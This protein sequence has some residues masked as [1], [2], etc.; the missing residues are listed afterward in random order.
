[1]G[2]TAPFFDIIFI[3]TE[4]LF[5]L[6]N[7]F[8]SIFQAHV[9]KL[10]SSVDKGVIF[11]S[12]VS[13][14]EL[15]DTYINSFP[16]DIRQSFNCNSC[17]QFIKSYGGLVKINPENMM[18]TTLW[19]FEVPDEMYQRVVDNLSELVFRSNI[20]DVFVSNQPKLGT[21]FNFE[22][23]KVNNITTEIIR[24]DHF[25]YHLNKE[26]YQKVNAEKDIVPTQAT[27][28][29]TKNV[30]K[31]ALDEITP[32][33][34]QSVIDLEKDGNLY[35]G[36]EFI[37]A[38]KSFQK[39]QDEYRR[40]V[41]ENSISVVLEQRKDNFAWVNC[42]KLGAR[43]RNSAI[44]TLLIDLSNDTDI[45]TAVNKYGSV[46]DPNNYK[47]VKVAP[48]Q[49]MVDDAL[50]TVIEL[51]YEDSLARRFANY[52]DVK[53]NNTIYLNR[54]DSRT[55]ANSENK[56]KVLFNKLK[57]EIPVSPKSLKNVQEITLDKFLNDEVPR[58][59]SIS[60]LFEKSKENNLVS[61][62]T[63]V[64]SEAPSLFKWEEG[65]GCH[66]SW[67]YNNGVADS[68]KEKV[69]K[70]GGK[71]DGKLRISLAWDNYTDL[72]LHVIEPKITGGETIYYG[73]KRSRK[74][75]GHLDIDMNIHPTTLEPV[76]NIIY[77]HDSNLIEGKYMIRVHNY[78][79][80][81]I[82][83]N[84]TV[85]VEFNDEVYTF[86]SQGIIRQGEYVYIANFTYTKK[87]GVVFPTEPKT[88]QVQSTKIWEIDTNKFQKVN[89]ILYSPNH[90]DGLEIGNKHLFFI[91][92]KCRNPKANGFFNEFLKDDLYRNHKRVFEMLTHKL[93]VEDDGQEQLSG[94]GFSL[95][96]NPTFYAKVES[97]GSTRIFKV[98]TK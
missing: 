36:S 31:R 39:L 83:Q 56:T 17:R 24:W 28:R 2:I 82:T 93:E 85:E 20:R 95:S 70:A 64:N 73:N 27:Y 43:V 63:A 75:G 45:E 98:V 18:M 61:L 7:Q 88:S 26:E 15:W 1:V 30:F 68:I 38:V 54:G 32:Y 3:H 34:V 67:S 60:I 29:D 51:G 22:T 23:L 10:M 94:L 72:D 77:S 96:S 8:K 65:E 92:D 66:L 37:A 89:M 19:N 91:L 33:A 87:F 55:I 35:R 86:D 16:E 49:R 59:D 12:D 80:R 90:W 57:E 42:Q 53:V 69:K 62:V 4:E 52:T 84:Y 50:Q 48:T 14:D 71:I 81:A 97:N 25:Y 79:N 78:T 11:I 21:D 76:E 6:F 58:A 74:T 47:R 13:K 5:M 40:L 44:G 46:V 41:A 9:T